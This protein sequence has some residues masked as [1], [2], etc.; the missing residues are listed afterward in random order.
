MAKSADA[1]EKE[2]KDFV[3]LIRKKYDVYAVVL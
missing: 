2:L 1:V 3:A